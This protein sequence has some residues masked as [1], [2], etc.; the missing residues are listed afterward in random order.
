V[1]TYAVRDDT[2]VIR[3]I[4]YQLVEKGH[5]PAELHKMSSI[6]SMQVCDG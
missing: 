4:G 2:Q 5:F 3:P 6:S 1:G